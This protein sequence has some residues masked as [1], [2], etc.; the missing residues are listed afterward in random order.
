LERVANLASGFHLITKLLSKSV[1]QFMSDDK[2]ELWESLKSN[3]AYQ[4]AVELGEIVWQIVSKWDWLAKKTIG[5]Q[6]IRSADSVS[7]NISEGWGKFTYKDKNNYFRTARGSLMETMNWTVKSERRG[8]ID[9]E[10]LQKLK[11]IFKTLPWEINKLTYYNN[12][13]S[14]EK[15]IN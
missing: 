11:I 7:A 9:Q 8:I 12:Q 5:E 3:R 6:Y 13:K 2:F 4:L 1:S 14:R 10:K 15:L